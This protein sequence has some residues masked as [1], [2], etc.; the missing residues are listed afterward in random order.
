MRGR[1]ETVKTTFNSIKRNERFQKIEQKIIERDG[2]PFAETRGK[3]L[4]LI[5]PIVC[6]N[7][8][9]NEEGC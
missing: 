1:K 3:L 6:G 9:F 8:I 4:D 2:L 7:R 5:E